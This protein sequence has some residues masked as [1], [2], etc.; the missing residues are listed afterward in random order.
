MKD[1]LLYIS[2]S[3]Y[4]YFGS[5]SCFNPPKA[6]SV[7]GSGITAHNSGQETGVSLVSLRLHGSSGR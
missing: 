6:K 1:S 3:P 4:C 2:P 5:D 7:G